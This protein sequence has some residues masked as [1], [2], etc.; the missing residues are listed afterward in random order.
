M[1]TIYGLDGIARTRKAGAILCVVVS[2]IALCGAL[3][4][5]RAQIPA[6]PAK[7]GSTRAKPATDGRLVSS[8]SRDEYLI[9]PEDVLDVNVY[10]MP[11]MSCECRV[12]PAGTVTLPLLRKPV[13]AA[14]MTPEQLAQSVEKDF[15]DAGLLSNPQVTV[16]VKESRRHSVAVSGA[17]KNP[18][19]YPL[20]GRIKLSDL[21]SQAG[22]LNDDAG[23]TVTISRG[24]LALHELA[25]GGK[26][27]PE[28]VT[29]DLSKLTKGGDQGPDA[30][31]FPGDRITVETAGVF[32]VL[33]EVNRPGGYNLRTAHEEVTV[34]QALAVA[35]DVTSLAKTRNATIIRKD[36]KAPAGRAQIALN[37][38]DV[39]T[40][41]APDR[42]VQA[43]DVLYV[44]SSRGKRTMRAIAGATGSA[45]GAATSGLILYRR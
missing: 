31:V 45:V 16:L 14:G 17:V 15:S 28:K 30:D 23:N 37:L 2:G 9:S 27:A 7:P 8:G 4:V 42:Q 33:G 13:E 5:L 24:T 6:P 32:Y 10:D 21:I 44:P 11:D 12:S 20:M 22:G 1:S 40:G 3:T 29:V 26:P 43:N 35:G 38:N 34:L 25:S 36:P 18:Q 41:R 19:T 39:L